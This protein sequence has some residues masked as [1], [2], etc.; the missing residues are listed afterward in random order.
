MATLGTNKI[1]MV[2]QPGRW[3][4]NVV[5]T[6]F[7]GQPLS[8][9]FDRVIE[10]LLIILLAFG[11]LAF[12]VVHAWSEQIILAI[13]ASMLGVFLVKCI[14]LPNTS[15]VRTWT[16]LPVA[17]FIL[18]ALFQILPLPSAVVSAI[19]TNTA[20]LKIELLGNVPGAEEALSSMSLSFYPL[21]TK[22]NVRLILAVAA[23]FVVVMNIYRQP[24]RIKRLL[25][26]ITIIGGAIALL[27]LVQDIAGNGKI[28]WTIPTY[29]QAHSGTF[30]N[31]NHY[32]QFMNLSIGAALGLLLVE[33][34]EAFA[35]CRM[36]P[37]E[38]FEYAGSEEAKVVKLL[39]V[40]IIL[41]AATVVVS[42][43]RGGMLSMLIAGA[44]TVLVL[45]SRQLLR[46]RSWLLVVMALGTFVCVLWIGFDQVYDR[47]ATL[48][49]FDTTVGGRW[50]MI[51]NTLAIWTRFPAFGT[52]LGTYRVVYPM[53]DQG[54]GT[55]LAT[56]AENEYVQTLAETGCTGLIALI[57]FGIAIWV[58]YSKSIT[59]GS[60]SITSAAY[61]LGFGL[62]AV[63]IHSLSDFG[64]HMPANAILTAT[65]CGL[66]IALSR[67]RHRVVPVHKSM[68]KKLAIGAAFL[69]ILALATSIFGWALLTANKARIAE[70]HWNEV[71]IAEGYLQ[72][73]NWQGN[74]QISS[75]LFS[76]AKAAVE[77]EPDNIHYRH[78][79]G[80]YQWLALQPHVDPNTDTLAPEWLP[81]AREI[82]E[83]L[84]RTRPLCPTFGATPCVAG[85]IEYFVL[86]DPEGIEHI[87]TGYRLAPCDP[88][89]CFA[90]ARVDAQQGKSDH[91]FEKASRAV[92]LDSSYF[93]RAASLCIDVLKRPD[94][95][96]VLAQDNVHQLAYVANLLVTSE[97]HSQLVEQIRNDIFTLLQHRSK[98]SDAPAG[99]FGSLASLYYQ[100]GDIQT[101][102]EH[103]RLAIKKD[104]D[105]VGWH[106]ALARLL[107][108]EG[109]VDE[110]SH[111]AE[112]CLR[113]RPD[114]RAAERLIEESSARSAAMEKM[115]VSG[116]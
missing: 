9:R 61:G 23:V 27:T 74:E 26:A 70:A 110:A 85:E 100:Q 88:T 50:H 37:R 104:Y 111:E 96:L 41:G 81:R 109:R 63:L 66:L 34:H 84:Q 14:I 58:K 80:V 8:E 18:L 31:H 32:G 98:Q 103:Y 105:Q 56:H 92:Q 30:V 20:K 83:T 101:A 113:L 82:A 62:L 106:Y 78:W 47:L 52:G 93:P 91:A 39:I 54:A 13:A 55:S 29:N 22:H 90:A 6:L 75:Q 86:G 51:K 108:E 115:P 7:V 116:Q 72:S 42:L 25:A 77:A 17:L 102:I 33:L 59:A 114:Y 1:S 24:G 38:I 43:T 4:G 95:A 79:L 16:Y 40:M 67:M 15:V 44:F 3:K 35:G 46:G 73:D 97:Q 11:P 5:S 64:Q 19:S 12:G 45:S 99:V 21:A 65:Y 36:S 60:A 10:V 49:E 2:L 107:D 69:F 57:A 76:H 28:Y 89:A 48:R 68:P 87:R 94:L 112:I 53:F 71:L